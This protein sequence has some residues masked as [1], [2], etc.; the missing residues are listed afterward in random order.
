MYHLLVRHRI[1]CTRKEV[2]QIYVNLRFL[3][4]R[5][6]ARART[7]DSR[8]EHPRYPNLVKN[9]VIKEPDQ[10]WV[11]DTLELRVAYRRAFLALIEDVYTRRVVGLSISFAN[12]T[13]LTIDAL[14]KALSKA[15]PQIHHSDQGKPYA[16]EEYTRR[17]LAKGVRISM[18]AVGC[19]WENGHAERLNRT[20]KE[21]EILRSEYQSLNEARSAI[22]AYAKLYNEHRIHMSLRYKTPNE[23]K[24]AYGQDQQTGE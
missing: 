18:A 20:F 6:P 8:H 1:A 3:G 14:E 5:A 2:R 17:L 24:K 9:L 7:T 4:K 13:L 10:V 15:T 12:N 23:V 11:A 19:A 21:E 16:A 22:T